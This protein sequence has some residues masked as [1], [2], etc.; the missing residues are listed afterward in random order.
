VLTHDQLPPGDGG[1]SVGQA[2]IAAALS[3]G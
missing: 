2:A 3:K 1:L